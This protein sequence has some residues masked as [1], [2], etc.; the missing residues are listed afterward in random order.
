MRRRLLPLPAQQGFRD[1]F[2]LPCPHPA[3][4]RGGGAI[5]PETMIS[6]KGMKAKM[7]C[8]FKRFLSLLLALTL[9]LSCVPMSV[10][11]AND[12]LKPTVTVSDA[13]REGA[14]FAVNFKADAM[15]EAQMAAYGEWYVDVVLTVNR[16]LPLNNKAGTG[17]SYLSILCPEMDMED[18]TDMPGG[19]ENVVIPANQP[20]GLL[21]LDNTELPYAYF[22]QMSGVGYAVIF[23]DSYLAANPGLKATVAMV[24]TNPENG[25]QITIA[26][27]EYESP[28]KAPELPQ[29]SVSNI[30][31]DNLTFGMNFKV[32]DVT[33]EQ[34]DYYGDWYADFELTINKDVTFDANGTGDGWLSGRYAAWNNGA[35]VN[36]PV[37]PVTI[38]ANES[39][40]IMEFAAE[41]LGQNGLQMTYKEILGQVKDF[42]CGV[43]FTPEFLEA[44]PDVKVTLELRMYNPANPGETY[45]VGEEYVFTP[46]DI[47]PALPTAKVTDILTENLTFAMNFTANDITEE[48]LAYYGK[49]YADFELTINKDVTFDANGTGDGWL[50]GQYD[51]WSKDWVNVPINPVTIEANK[52]LKIMEFAAELLGQDGLKMTYEEILNDV[53]DFDCGVY[54]TPEFLEANPDVKVTLELRMYNPANPSE[55]HTVGNEYVF[56]QEDIKPNLPTATIT[57]TE[58]ENLTFAMNF[59]ADEITDAQL[60]Y[61]QNWFVDFELTINKDVTFNANGGADG[62]LSGCYDAWQEGQWI[63][64]PFD[65]EEGVSLTAGQTIKIM[66]FAAELL[67]EPGLKYTFEEVFESVKDFTCGIFFEP[68]FLAANPDLEVTLKLK[69][70]NPQNADETYSVGETYV[71]ENDFVAYNVDTEKAYTELSDAMREAENGQTVKLI[72]NAEERVANVLIGVTLDLNGYE[73]TAPYLFCVGNIV[74]DSEGNT[75]VLKSEHV[76]IR[77]DNAQ[78]PVKCAADAYKFYEVVKFN[79]AVLTSANNANVPAGTTKFVFQPIFEAVAHEYLLAGKET[80]GVSIMVCAN[81][82]RE[83]GT[84]AEQEFIYTDAQV[85]Q[86]ITSYKSNV[87]YGKDFTLLLKNAD[88]YEGIT[89][90]ARV[91]SNTGAVFHSNPY[92]LNGSN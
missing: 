29:A 44:N 17:C 14:A 13:E 3:E 23:Q 87:K 8:N 50:S 78:L 9:A 62:W 82:I 51:A 43:Y 48:Q 36:V 42:D 4:Q 92:N 34:M 20:W 28:V 2:A 26:S 40:K 7:K 68:E 80:S 69:M 24:L 81:W 47:K 91:V 39:L 57:E 11:A 73:L 38:E 6:M 54:F 74:D 25:E 12:D 16:E 63:N 33:E 41:L 18:W 70:Y 79:V 49:W 59:K 5:L 67:G 85:Q 45:T 64:V 22:A 19:D 37:T 77:E 31:V 83:D 89:C 84:A 56:E 46:E 53:K 35:W 30:Y 65:K 55:T 52:P 88:S 32:D 72:R 86:Y 75:G 66:E 76:M 21:A 10:F 15:T 90:T 71:F 60:E 58:N 1:A 27:Y 61:Y